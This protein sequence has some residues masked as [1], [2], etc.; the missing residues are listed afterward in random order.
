ME[1]KLTPAAG[2]RFARDTKRL[3]GKQL[4]ILYDGKLLIAPK[5]YSIMRDKFRISG[6]FSEAEAVSLA[7]RIKSN[8]QGKVHVKEA[9]TTWT[10]PENPDPNVIRKEAKEDKRKG[11]YK[12]AITKHLWYHQNASVIEPSLSGAWTSFAQGDWLELGE[13]YPPALQKMKQVRDE[14]EKR[15]RNEELVRVRFSDFQDFAALNRTLREHDRTLGVFQWLDEKDPEDAARLFRVPRKSLIKRKA[16]ELYGKYVQPQEEMERIQESYQ[17]TFDFDD[18][19][20]GDIFFKHAEK[21]LLNDVGTLVALLVKID[22]VPE[23]KQVAEESMQI[24]EGDEFNER[25]RVQLKSAMQGTM[26][27]P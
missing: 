19:K 8:R 23:A 16:H 24:I 6:N 9:S 21:K 4:A 14:T 22:R 27:G 5:V 18:W 10:P 20:Y 26:P 25:L 15:I 17:Q 1:V 2:E 12:I 3:I 7:S 13:V 11:R